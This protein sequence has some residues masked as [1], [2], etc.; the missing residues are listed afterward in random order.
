LGDTELSYEAEDFA[1]SVVTGDDA[2]R[3]GVIDSADAFPNNPNE[4]LDSDGDG[5]GDNEEGVL[6][7]DPQLADSDG[8]GLED[9]TEIAMLFDPLSADSDGDGT[10][11]ASDHE[12]DLG[13]YDLAESTGAID[14]YFAPTPA[15][16]LDDYG[17]S[18]RFSSNAAL[19]ARMN[20]QVVELSAPTQ[21]LTDGIYA[22]QNTQGWSA[23]VKPVVRIDFASME[24]GMASRVSGYF[25]TW[26][27]FDD[28]LM[29]DK[30]SGS[31]SDI[32]D[33]D[34]LAINNVQ[35]SNASEGAD[36]KSLNLYL[37]TD[38]YKNLSA[39][40]DRDAQAIAVS[41]IRL[42]LNRTTTSGSSFGSTYIG[43]E[44]EKFLLTPTQTD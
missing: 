25:G 37:D 33:F 35:M 11:D 41:E 22:Y 18:H 24:A 21:I 28:I 13:D 29:T 30:E 17:D 20:N 40:S 19:Q 4:T 6:G 2:D 23:A 16:A 32:G 34:F 43:L 27:S 5:L 7:T 31:S 26:G 12:F 42:R 1:Y 3:D 36:V 8:D 14:T 15:I 38:I 44:T 9:A 10:N 39:V